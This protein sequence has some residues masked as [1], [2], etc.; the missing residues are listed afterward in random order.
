MIK[1]SSLSVLSL[2][3]GGLMNIHKNNKLLIDFSKPLSE[4]RIITDATERQAGKSHGDLSFQNG[5]S[6]KKHYFF[7]HLRPQPNGAAFVSF[8]IPM[9]LTMRLEQS[10]CLTAQG[11]T[12][13]AAIYQLIINTSQS[14]KMHVSYQ[15]RFQAQ[16]GNLKTYHFSLSRFEAYFRGK[17]YQ[18][19]PLQDPIDIVAIGVRIIGRED[20]LQKG[21]Y[22]LALYSVAMCD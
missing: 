19:A 7:A 18:R 14:A 21:L 20:T 13:D 10:L 12:S 11:L 17:P 9:N 2:T 3:L 5:M 22:G 16:F 1:T 8:K 4:Y 6:E 15:H